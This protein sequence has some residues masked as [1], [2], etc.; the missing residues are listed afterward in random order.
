MSI[1]SV[2]TGDIVNSTKLDDSSEKRL[3]QKLHQILEPYT[4]EFFRGDSFQAYVQ[5]SSTSLQTALMCRTAA[6]GLNPEAT[7]VI[8]DVRIS[9]GL[10]EVQHPIEN[11]ASA[12][13]EAFVLSG[14]ALDSLEKTEGRLVI[15]TENNALANLAFTVMADYINSI[16]KQMTA[17]QAEVILEL[18]KGET[19]QQVADKL[20]RSKSTI[21]QHVTAG[22]WDEIENILTNYKRITELL[23]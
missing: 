8:S 17:K 15:I 16:Y 14:R 1:H 20:N 11:L 13:G 22:R 4:F 5:D 3:L 7:T 19:Q 21:S 23:T 6:I 9:I 2:I 12:K 10:G 18:L